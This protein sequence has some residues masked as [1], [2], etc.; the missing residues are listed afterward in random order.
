MKLSSF[1]IAASAVISASASKLTR[2]GT[3]DPSERLKYAL[4]ETAFRYALYRNGTTRSIDTYSHVVT[5]QQKE[6][7]YTEEQI[8]QQV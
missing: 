7:T 5:T 4:D 3:A 8:A 2:C 1:V 6:G